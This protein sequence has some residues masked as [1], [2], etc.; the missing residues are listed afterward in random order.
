[1]KY[2]SKFFR[3][4]RLFDLYQSDLY[5][6]C[7]NTRKQEALEP[8]NILGGSNNYC[9]CVM[10]TLRNANLATN[11]V[12]GDISKACEYRTKN[13]YSQAPTYRDTSI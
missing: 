11:T 1:M 5:N 7:C 6:F 4:G 9:L 3:V 13:D 2:A 12:H 10:Q 8:P